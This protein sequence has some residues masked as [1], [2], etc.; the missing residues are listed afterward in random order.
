MSAPT[1]GTAEWLAQV[2]EPIMDPAQAI[3]DPH[4][5]LWRRDA[6]NYLLDD[7]WSDTQTGHDVQKTVF[8]ECRANYRASGPE[9]LRCVGETEFVAEIAQASQQSSDKATISAI[10]GHA[11]LDRKS[12]RLN[13]SH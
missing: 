9:H 4:H 6:S 13:S 7:L 10:V 12:T 2:T 11:D 1:P 3:V 5:H 8:I